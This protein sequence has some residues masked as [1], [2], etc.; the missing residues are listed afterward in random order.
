[1]A[2]SGYEKPLTEYSKD[3]LVQI[4][5]N[6]N[7]YHRSV[8]GVGKIG[9]YKRLTKK[10]LIDLIQDDFDYLDAN[11]KKPKKPRVPN[12]TVISRY[13]KLRY[14]KKYLT[15]S[16]TPGYL[17]NEILSILEGRER[18]FPIPGKFYTYIYYAATPKILYDQHP[19]IRANAILKKGFNGFNYHLGQIRQYNTEDGDRLVSGLY[20]VKQEELIILR[21][22][23]YGKLIQK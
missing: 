15:G 4:A 8:T 10:Q 9:G 21:G 20:E 6:Y 23:P 7:I 13:N 22:I 1:M 2:L 18:A 11:P 5:E 16:E 19:L 3:E 14:L 12:S 17:I